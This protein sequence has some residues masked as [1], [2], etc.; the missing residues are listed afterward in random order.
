M[1]DQDSVKVEKSEKFVK[2]TYKVTAGDTSGI[3]V[4]YYFAFQDH[5]IDLHIS[6]FPPGPDDAEKFAAFEKSLVYEKIKAKDKP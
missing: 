3:N 4:N 5:W 1:I 6:R 2:V